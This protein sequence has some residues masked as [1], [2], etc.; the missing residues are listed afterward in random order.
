MKRTVL[1]MLLLA[2]C[3][4]LVYGGAKRIQ[5][6]EGVI[7]ISLVGHDSTGSATTMKPSDKT[8]IMNDLHGQKFDRVWGSAY[9]DDL[10]SDS[11]TYEGAIDTVIVRYCFGTDWYKI[12]AEVDTFY[13]P[14]S[15]IFVLDENIWADYG[16]WVGGDSTSALLLPSLTG[17]FPALMCEDF[18]IEYWV[19]DTAG[20]MGVTAAPVAG[21][22]KYFFNFVEDD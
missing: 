3:T 21:T 20:T 8:R 14:D 6:V 4:S 22:L 13:P 12:V 10:A 17:D 19:C 7:A 16:K 18:W 5:K 9:M 11:A 2:I 1:V 15:S